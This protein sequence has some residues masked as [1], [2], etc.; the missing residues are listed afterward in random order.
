CLCNHCVAMPTILESRCCQVI[1]KV[2]EKADAANCKCITEH[3]G[4]SV[5]CTNIHVLET[6]YYEYHRINGPLE[7]N[8]EI[9]E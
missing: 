7:E 6:S 9:H 2:K 5:N 8:Q 1:G 4:F 3:E